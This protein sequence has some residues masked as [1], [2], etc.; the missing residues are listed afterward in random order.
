MRKLS[1][2]LYAFTGLLVGHVYALEDG[3]GELTL[4]DASVGSAAPKVIHQLETAGRKPSDVKRILVTHAH[5]DH[6]GGLPELQRLTGADVL[7]LDI[8]RD[9]VEG[10]DAAPIAPPE[11]QGLMRPFVPKD[12]R[13]ARGTPVA[14]TLHDGEMIEESFGGL[15]ALHTPGHSPG[16]TSF[17]QPQRRILFTGDVLMHLPWGLTLPIS[18]FTTDMDENRRSITHLGQ[19]GAAIVCF[20]HGSPLTEDAAGKMRSAAAKLGR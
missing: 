4:I 15:Q 19:L 16:H 14:R 7:C 3:D 9:F 18:A 13:L 5:P 6:I 12:K 2:G 11:R 10:R 17:W 8:E 1:D 20:G